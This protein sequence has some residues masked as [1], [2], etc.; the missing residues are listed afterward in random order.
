MSQQDS[1]LSIAASVTGI[2]TFAG[3][4]VA[5][6]YARAISLRNA[7]DTQAEVSSA[8]EKID[9]LETETNMLNN[10]YLASQIRHP[11]RKYGSGDF[12]YFHGLLHQSLQRM[13]QMDRGLRRNAEMVTGGNSYDKLSR[14]K[15]AAT[16]MAARNRIHQ[17][18]EERQAESHRIFQIQLAILSAKIDELSYH[19][20]HHNANCSMIEEFGTLQRAVDAKLGDE[21]VDYDEDEEKENRT[22][23]C[24]IDPDGPQVKSIGSQKSTTQQLRPGPDLNKSSRLSYHLDSIINV[25]TNS[26]TSLERSWRISSEEPQ[27]WSEPPVTVIEHVENEQTSTIRVV[28]EADTK[29]ELYDDSLAF[30]YNPAVVAFIGEGKVCK[31][32]SPKVRSPSP[33]ASHHSHGSSCTLF[34]YSPTAP[35]TIILTTPDDDTPP[36]TPRPTSE[37]KNP[38]HAIR[39]IRTSTPIPP[40]PPTNSSTVGLSPPLDRTRLMPPSER[41]LNSRKIQKA[42]EFREIRSFMINFMNTSGDTFPMKLRFKMMDMYCIREGDLDPDMSQSMLPKKL[43]PQLP[44]PSPPNAPKRY[45]SASRRVGQTNIP[46]TIRA[47]APPSPSPSPTL[48]LPSPS[49]PPPP[50]PSKDVPSPP[51]PRPY[52][53]DLPLAWLAPMISTSSSDPS[54]FDPTH[55]LRKARSAPNLN[56]NLPLL[57]FDENGE[58]IPASPY[59]LGKGFNRSDTALPDSSPQKKR[60]SIL[61]STFSAVRLAL[62]S[63]ATTTKISARDE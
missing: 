12:K 19:Q 51:D 23:V 30:D 21:N 60:N 55:S 45:K 49:P 52:E 13:R 61:T 44:G 47:I 7:I 10:A 15:T 62:F 57:N 26:V 2:L 54:Y 11:D 6:F 63:P 22:E 50:V 16:W 25:W 32:R 37:R 9:F 31:P 58:P 33:K 1:P 24:K 56:K 8:L 42:Q 40:M 28:Q 35:I 38:F 53:D 29:S 14:V 41:S 39:S 27:P 46:P 18:I 36:P 48:A 43:H 20:N 3:A 34:E 5:G 59:Q 17:D 4:I